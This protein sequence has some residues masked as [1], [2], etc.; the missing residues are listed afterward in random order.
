MVLPVHDEIIFLIAEGEEHL[1][2]RLKAFMEDTYAIIKNIPMVAEIE[3][4]K[5][6]WR[7]KVEY[8]G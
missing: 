1:V 3:F 6:N 2:H 8:D 7:E 4:S 5:T